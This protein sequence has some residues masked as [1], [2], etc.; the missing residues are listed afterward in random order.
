VQLEGRALADDDLRRAA[1]ERGQRRPDVAGDP[2]VAP[3]AAQDVPEPL[4]HRRLPV[5]A[6]DRHERAVQEPPAQLDLAEHGQPALARGG[7]DRGARRDP[8]RLG[9][10]G[11]RVELGQPVRPQ[12]HGER[13]RRVEH[14]RPG[15][16]PDHALAP[17]GQQPPGGQPRA[18]EADD[19]PGA[20]GQRRAGR[21]RQE[22]DA[23]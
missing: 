7:D 5:R 8:R 22:I 23:W 20:G 19:E 9:H 12:P 21:G 16:H 13:G 17:A 10:R 2:H 11:G 6:G 1:D 4:G 18:G 15:V 3:R 14:R